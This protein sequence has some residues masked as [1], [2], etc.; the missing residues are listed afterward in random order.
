[1]RRSSVREGHFD[2]RKHARLG[3]WVR[4]DAQKGESIVGARAVSYGYGWMVEEGCELDDLVWHNGDVDGFT[5]AIGFL[6]LRG[7][8]VVALAN[9]ASPSLHLRDLVESILLAMK[10]TGALSLRVAPV[11]LPPALQAAMKRVLGLYQVWDEPAYNATASPAAASA[12]AQR[13]ALAHHR[14]LHGACDGFTPYQIAGTRFA[15]ATVR[16]ERGTLDLGVEID[17]AGLI[18]HIDAVSRDVTPPPAVAKAAARV[19]GLVGKWDEGTY[20]AILAANTH[21]TRAHRVAFFADLRAK[22]GACTVGPYVSRPEKH[23]LTLPCAR[24]GDLA[25]TLELDPQND[26]RIFDFS[27]APRDDDG[28]CPLKR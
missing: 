9:L 20:R 11:V 23:E 13:K 5:S 14:S 21:D 10:K 25:L 12:N 16:C 22:H 26:E 7:V 17:D 4:D 6:P 2:A 27:L 18:S 8:G 15:R 1:V 28:P 24:G 3:T 19:A